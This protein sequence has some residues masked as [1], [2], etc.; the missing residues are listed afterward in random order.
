MAQIEARATMLVPSSRMPTPRPGCSSAPRPS[1]ASRI[2]TPNLPACRR[3]RSASSAPLMPW[4]ETQ[5]VLDARTA[6]GLTADRPALD[7]HGVQPVGAAIHRGAQAGRA[8]A[9][10]RQVV[11]GARG[12]AEPAQLVGDLP[13]RRRLQPGAV[14][15]HAP[16]LW[17]GR[18]LRPAPTRTARRSGAGN[19]G[20]RT[21]PRCRGGH[22]CRTLRSS[23]AAGAAA[24]SCL[25][26]FAIAG[27]SVGRCSCCR[28]VVPQR[29]DARF[30]GRMAREE[31]R[32]GGP[33]A[34]PKAWSACG[35]A[36]GSR[37]PRRRSAAIIGRG[38]PSSARRTRV[39]AEL[40][41]AREPRDDDRGEDA[42]Q[43]LADE[44]GDVVA[45]ARRR[46]RSLKTALST[47]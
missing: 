22:R 47:T 2:S 29:G 44:H 32:A 13:D 34:M 46:A 8:G 43:D 36:P 17:R 15:K 1:R 16:G 9:V 11:F 26:S 28:P 31:A 40:A 20:W 45:H 33:S 25:S 41:L 42:E 24:A 6:A 27:L 4:S 10:D 3:A 7:Q 21:P 35:S 39:G 23:P 19:H 38:E 5:V 14:G 18:R 30:D 37:P 12:T